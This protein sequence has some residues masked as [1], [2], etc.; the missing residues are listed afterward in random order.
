MKAESVRH[1]LL[2]GV[3]R[4]RARLT[5]ALRGTPAWSP[6]RAVYHAVSPLWRNGFVRSALM[7]LRQRLYAADPR[8]YWQQEGHGYMRDEAFLLG[9]ASVTERQGRFLAA[10]IQALGAESALEMGCGYGRLLK[11]VRQRLDARLVGADFSESQLRT[12]RGYLAPVRVPLVLAD[13]TQGLPFRDSA[14]DVVYTQGSLMHVPSH[15]GRAYRSELARVSRRYIIHTEDARETEITFVHDNERH[16]REL[17]H[18]V[19]KRAPYPFNLPGQRMTFEVFERA[20]PRRVR[21]R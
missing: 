8:G 1:F 13:A 12:A 5:W 9:P 14:F 20:Q 18:R 17:D 10:E 7:P 2:T 19:V 16:Y 21:R 6:L 15:L 3:K 4:G 11:E